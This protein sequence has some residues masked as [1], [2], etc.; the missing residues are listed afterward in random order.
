MAMSY[1][2]RYLMMLFPVGPAAATLSGTG[3][4]PGVTTG[5]SGIYVSRVTRRIYSR[6]TSGEIMSIHSYR[7]GRE[8][9]F[10]SFQV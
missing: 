5:G 8:D 4:P 1:C 7:D 10:E 9:W 6:Q 2:V 3:K